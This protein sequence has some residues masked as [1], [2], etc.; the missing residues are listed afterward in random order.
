MSNF[1]KIA[2]KAA[3]D[4]Y[5]NEEFVRDQF[6]DWRNNDV[7]K[8]WLKDMGY[9]PQ[10]IKKIQAYLGK[11]KGFHGGKG[12]VI[13]II[14]GKEEKISVKYFS[15]GYNQVNR[16]WIDAYADKWEFPENTTILLKKYLGE[17]GFQVQDYM[18]EDEIKELNEKR[19]SYLN[20]RTIKA[21]KKHKRLH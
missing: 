3:K 15:A 9:D 4:G 5:R 1:S 7:A 12:D 8:Q 14:D 20:S 13:V 6:N 10:K 16:A 2:S 19:E 17:K 18:K 11:E 21:I